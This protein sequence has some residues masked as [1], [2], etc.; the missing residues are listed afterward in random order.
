[1]QQGWLRSG[2]IVLFLGVIFCYWLPV[3]A[4]TSTCPEGG[5]CIFNDTGPILIKSQK[6]DIKLQATS[7]LNNIYLN[8]VD[9]A[10]YGLGVS[11]GGALY[12]NGN[13]IVVADGEFYGISISGLSGGLLGQIGTYAPEDLLKL[14]NSQQVFTF[15]TSTAYWGVNDITHSVNGLSNI[16]SWLTTNLVGQLA[17]VRDSD[18][19]SSRQYLQ[20]RFNNVNSPNDW[21]EWTEVCDIS[22]NCR[23][24]FNVS[25]DNN[26]NN[27]LVMY[28]DPDILIDSGLKVI[29]PSLLSDC[30]NLY[31]SSGVIGCGSGG[32]GGGG[33][34]SGLGTAN[35]LSKWSDTSTLADS[36]LYEDSNKI[37][38]GTTSPYTQLHIYNNSEG[39]IIS[40]SGLDIKYRGLTIKDT[41]NSEKWFVGNNDS[42]N[43][44][45]RATGS[46]DILTVGASS[47]NVG[48]GTASPE[49]QLTITKNFRLSPTTHENLNGIIYKDGNR[50][51]HDFNYGYSGSTT[52]VGQNT[53][54]GINAGNLTMGEGVIS[55]FQAS[56]NV[57]V[58]AS[59]FTSNTSGNYNTAVGASSLY[60]NTSGANNT[61]FG[62]SALTSNTSGNYNTAVGASSLYSN[63]SGYNTAV[64]YASLYSN[65]SGYYNTAV[66]A[67][68]LYSNT[69][70]YSNTALG[71]YALYSNISGYN[72]AVGYASLRSNISGNYN[73]AVGASSL[74]SN[75]SSD[76]N[77]A[78]GYYALY[79]NKAGSNNVAVGI[80]AGNLV[81]AGSALTKPTNS[82][83]L[84][85][86]T[87][88][89]LDDQ[90]NQIVIGVNAI[91]AGSNSVVLGNTSI[92]K[93]LLRGDIGI[94]TSSPATKLHIYDASSGPIITLS[95]LDTNYRG[96]VI[97][98]TSD[99]E[100]WFI[101]SNTST[102]T[103]FVIRATSSNDIL[104]V[105]TSNG[106][107]GIGTM[108]DDI[109]K[110]NVAGTIKT[111]LTTT[112]EG[113][114]R[115][116]YVDKDG[117]ISAK[118]S[119]CG[120]DSSSISGS[121]T[122][123]YLTKWSNANTLG[124]STIYDNGTNVSIGTTSSEGTLMV[125]GTGYFTGILKVATPVTSS[126]AVN[127]SY[128][129]EAMK[130]T[131]DVIFA[132]HTGPYYNGAN[133]GYDNA[134]AICDTAYDGSHICTTED[135]LRIIN[136][137]NVNSIPT[138][139][140]GYW[141]VNG[142]PAYTAN[143]NDCVGFTTSSSAM[144]GNVWIKPPE[145]PNSFG[146]LRHCNQ[147]HQFACCKYIYD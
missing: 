139:T 83:F 82:I 14:K 124:T 48:I 107:V 118:T 42:N 35:Y 114:S 37:G 63:T 92:T 4:S 132:G 53:F 75:T 24:F 19:T 86:E 47:G 111:N 103:N 69:S 43:F 8:Y 137:G 116:L 81:S 79:N 27:S 74:Y 6:G 58:G 51:I 2:I 16:Y 106:N 140:I 41:N 94:G 46:N 85:A 120:T 108:P 141:I 3:A 28:Q 76:N 64:G 26:S 36:I 84:G 25:L 60:S 123:N 20:Y 99:A 146:I 21:D 13:V 147:E 23:N 56:Y 52:T 10:S 110:L 144:L 29:D 7:T 50:F 62:Y 65:I 67:S 131:H 73:T 22:N 30:S 112:T 57:G 66:G 90:T 12:H 119:D 34:L 77:T 91:G 125:S 100:K 135:I 128:L 130:S 109:V 31:T 45:I 117:V 138:T 15:S 113:I 55:P 61:A 17:F 133:G 93:T 143:A 98:D 102:N 68:S 33:G 104:T 101:G 97:K 72:T 121:G 122:D 59:A 145:Y 32:G 115:C 89:Q 18:S 70:S 38:L 1:M 88:A 129:I 71:Y 11:A 127:L 49:E 54:I 80:R 40:L 44:V 142:P 126:D 95:G 9:T 39:P 78:L 5:K 87:K 136:S 134:N 105:G 96:L